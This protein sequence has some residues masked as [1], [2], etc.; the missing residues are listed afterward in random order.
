MSH[1]VDLAL[2]S[3]ELEGEATNDGDKLLT[4]LAPVRC[5]RVGGL[6]VREG[7]GTGCGAPWHACG[8]AQGLDGGGGVDS[9]GKVGARGGCCSPT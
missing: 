1:A 4:T 8:G 7:G 5:A 3:L 2:Q 6:R 9:A